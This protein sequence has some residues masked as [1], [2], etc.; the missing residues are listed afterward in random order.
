MRRSLELYGHSQPVV[1]Y[2]DNM[3][4]KSFLEASFPSLHANVVPVEKYGELEPFV[5]P[6]DVEVHVRRGENEID[7][8]LAT[9][10]DRVP[11]EADENLVIGF[12]AEWN[13]RLEDNGRFEHGTIAIVQIAF[14]KRVEILQVRTCPSQYNIVKSCYRLANCWRIESYHTCSRCYSKTLA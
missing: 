13:V 1:F 9:I 11:V 4:D 3:A 8:A 6:S 2:T 7:T 5:L 10:I 14:E 12:D